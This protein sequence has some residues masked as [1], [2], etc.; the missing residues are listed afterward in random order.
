MTQTCDTSAYQAAELAARSLLHRLDPKADY[1]PFFDL[2]VKDGLMT[3]NHASWDCVDMSS[4]FTDAWILAR[5]M[6]DWPVTE[7]EEAVKRYLLATQSPDDGLFYDFSLP[8]TPPQPSPQR[9]GRCRAQDSLPV[10]GRAGEGSP[11]RGEGHP[12]LGVP[13]TADMFCQSRAIMALTSWYLESG[14]QQ[15]EERI[16]RL[17]EG[18]WNI[19]AKQ[20]D[21]C[22]YPGHRYSPEGWTGVSAYDS[23]D[24]GPGALPAYGVLQILPLMRYWESTESPAAIRLI[25]ALVNFF[26]YQ[27]GVVHMDGRFRGHLHSWGILPSTVGVLRYAMATEDDGLM[28]WCSKVGN[29][30][31]ANSSSFGWVPDGIDYEDGIVTGETCCCTDLIHLG[32]KLAECGAEEC[33]DYVEIMVRNQMLENQIRDVSRLSFASPEV[34]AMTLGAYDSW[35]MPNDL[36]GCSPLGLEG[37]CTASAVRGFYLAWSHAI[38]VSGSEVKVNLMMSRRS[39][40]VDVMSY[41]PWEGR[42]SVLAHKACDVLIRMPGWLNGAEL[43]ISV[44]GSAGEPRPDGQHLRLDDV[45]AGSKI[46]LTFPV[47]EHQTEESIRDTNYRLSWRGVTLMKIDPPGTIYPIFQ[48]T[49]ESM[50]DQSRFDLS[51]TKTGPLVVW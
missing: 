45:Q 13:E 29:F 43:D 27:S 1:R 46:D 24:L 4:R 26:V 11:V 3:A 41:Q 12:V 37:C 32:I 50:R 5:Q 9:G 23:K 31:V 14:D 19:A 7:E 8:E 10:A 17:I 6:F 40:W 30:I 39:E 38:D 35:V 22:Y 51:R 34:E 20:D 2:S 48:R 21:F 44:S 36:T 25:R 28:G 33:L 16:E 49:L 18:L 42:L 15:I 47:G